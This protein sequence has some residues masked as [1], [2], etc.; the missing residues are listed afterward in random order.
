ME[1]QI[2]KNILEI[3][4]EILAIQNKKKKLIRKIETYKQFNTDD[5]CKGVKAN[6]EKAEKT[7]K[8]FHNLYKTAEEATEMEIQEKRDKIESNNARLE[9]EIQRLKD[10]NAVRNNKLEKEIEFLEDED[11]VKSIVYYK[12]QMK[13]FKAKAEEE[14]IPLKSLAHLQ[15]EN[16]LKETEEQEIYFKKLQEESMESEIDLI[17]VRKQFDEYIRCKREKEKKIIEDNKEAH[18]QASLEISKNGWYY[19]KECEDRANQPIFGIFGS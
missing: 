2:S 4:D 11:N 6:K 9:I 1:Q 14:Y 17:E 16:E 8:N 3:N 19:S 5:T 12:E 18:L 7:Y 10:A 15:L 13:I